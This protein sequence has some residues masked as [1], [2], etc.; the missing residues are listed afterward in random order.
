MQCAENELKIK[1]LNKEK[2]EA[3][4]NVTQKLLLHYYVVLILFKEEKSSIDSSDD[5]LR[6]IYAYI[7]ENVVN[8]FKRS[9][10]I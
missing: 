3:I 6:R 4:N 10:Q 9:V 1:E 5:F 2:L 8:S 7:S